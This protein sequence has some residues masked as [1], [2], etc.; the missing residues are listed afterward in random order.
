MNFYALEN[1]VVKR[2][3]FD[4]PGPATVVASGVEYLREGLS[5]TTIILKE[6]ILC[7]GVFQSPQILELLGIGDLID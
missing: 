4:T 6:V 5:H 1:V 3:L 7:V 2:V